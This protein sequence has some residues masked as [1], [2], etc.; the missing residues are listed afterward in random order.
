[1]GLRF[2]SARRLRRLGGGVGRR[3]PRLAGGARHLDRDLQRLH[4]AGVVHARRLGRCGLVDGGR[5][6]LGRRGN[7]IG[8]QGGLAAPC[9]GAPR[10]RAQ[11]HQH[12]D[13]HAVGVEQ[14][15]LDGQEALTLAGAQGQRLLGLLLVGIH[16]AVFQPLRHRRGEDVVQA[17][18]REFAFG[19]AHQVGEG[20]V[21]AQE[22]A[23]RVGDK[24]GVGQGV[25]QAAGQGFGIVARLLRLQQAVALAQQDQGGEQQQQRRAEDQGQHRL[26][27]QA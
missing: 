8:E 5:G 18:R 2:G 21:D 3:R 12:P 10:C 26:L 7:G 20:G 22:A 9:G 23:G 27:R 14:R 4:Q 16:R 6:G 13:E 24:G 17:Q 19:P 11:L 1:M 15:R 25:E